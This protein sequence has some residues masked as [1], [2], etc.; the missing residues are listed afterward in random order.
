LTLVALA[1][2][3]LLQAVGHQFNIG[4]VGLLGPLDNGMQQNYFGL[5]HSKKHACDAVADL[6]A[7][8][9]DRPPQMIDPW[10]AYRPFLLD[11]GNVFTNGQAICFSKVFSHSRIGSLPEPDR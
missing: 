10:F 5:L 7:H 6:A 8:F 2:D 1:I 3:P 9:P 11:I 4:E